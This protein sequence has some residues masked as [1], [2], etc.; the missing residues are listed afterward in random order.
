PDNERRRIAADRCAY[1]SSKIESLR[2]D[3]G[4]LPQP[5]RGAL[6]KIDVDPQRTLICNSFDLRDGAGEKV[7]LWR[8]CGVNRAA[9]FVQ[10]LNVLADAG[11]LSGKVLRRFDR[12][13]RNMQEFQF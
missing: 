7:S 1:V 13:R 11:N 10:S 6:S 3:C 9:L 2:T 12:W 8:R 5:K 4:P